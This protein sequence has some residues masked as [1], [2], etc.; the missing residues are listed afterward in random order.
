MS[1]TINQYWPA[2]LPSTFQYQYGE[3][4]LHEYIAHHAKQRPNHVA[5]HY[6]GNPITWSKLDEDINRLARFLHDR[7]IVKGERVALFMQNSPQYIIGY[8]GVQKIGATVVP[9][10]PMYKEA[11][12]EY[13]I[14]EV[15][16]KAVILTDDLFPRLG[17]IM[18][19][20]PSV[21]LVM[22]TNYQDYV[23]AEPTLPLPE[24]LTMPKKSFE[25]TVDFKV[26]IEQTKRLQNDVEIDLWND[27][28][29]MAFTSGTTGRPKAAML[30]Y[31]NA[32]FKAASS[33]NAFGFTENDRTIV[34]PPLVHIGGKVI[35]I[36]IPI[37]SGCESV[38]LTRFDVEATIQA[39][40]KYKIN[41][42]YT[43]PPMNV[44]ILEHADAN[45]RDY[46]SLEV[47][48]ATSFGIPVSE[49][50]AE[51]WYQF[52]GGCSM[53]E[54]TYGL[55]ETHDV[56][57]LM[58]KDKVK[59]GSVG[60]PTFETKMKIIDLETGERLGAGQ[61]G[62][63]VIKSPGVFKGY[64]KRPEDTEQ[65]LKNG[66]LHTG[67][68]GSFDEDGYLYLH[69]RV[70]E[71]IKSSGFSV[72]PEDVEALLDKHEA[73]LQSAVIGVA[74]ERRGQSVKAFVVLKDA[75]KGKLTSDDII[76]WAKDNM[77]AY[78]YPR[79]VEFRDSLPASIS[80]KVLRKYLAKEKNV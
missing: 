80:G 65:T 45:K 67:D 37:Y 79:Y 35:G 53:Y 46:S 9:L 49:E 69:G 8:F 41:L 3:K 73:I 61:Q 50:L 78:K 70:K 51:K 5:Y 23:P 7:G 30:T 60:V 64:Y 43:L 66:W 11:E 20:I 16:V 77:S 12:L 32:L 74:D 52:T 76:A 54:A 18:D 28:C 33:T 6:Y 55:S 62:E 10:N 19:K 48:F 47:N 34:I 38:L 25:Q 2:Y 27:V 56:D 75:Y 22:T 57:T 24:E 72:F 17:A 71:M 40:E 31:G 14:N 21:E 29:L 4:P 1:S 15:A 13:F 58:P 63:I 68:I 39:I 42:L 44:A 26:A 36:N 59:Y